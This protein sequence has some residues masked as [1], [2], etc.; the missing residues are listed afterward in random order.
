MKYEQDGCTLICGDSR[1]VL[2][3]MPAVDLICTSPPYNIGSKAERNDGHRSKGAYDPKSFGAVR[4]YPDDKPED[5]YQAEQAE[6]MRWM[7]SKLTDHG[8]LVYNHKPRHKNRRLIKPEAW[9]PYDTLSQVD[10]IIWDRGSTHNHCKAFCYQQTERLY[11]FTRNGCERQQYF[12]NEGLGDVWKI[13]RERVE[14]SGHDARFPLDLARR[15]IRLWSRPGAVVCDPYSGS[16]TTMLAA[17]LEGR[18]FIGAEMMPEHYR[19]SIA[20]LQNASE[21]KMAV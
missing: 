4:S 3:D 20:R 5:V 18:R 9:F 10:E 12:E 15:I 13:L 6:M 2:A 16:G 7:G 14:G 17:Y 11:V 19:E 8:T 1:K 21:I